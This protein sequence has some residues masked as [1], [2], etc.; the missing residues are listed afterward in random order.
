[1][2]FPFHEWKHLG[3]DEVQEPFRMAIFP[4]ISDPR[5]GPEIHEPQLAVVQVLA[6][7]RETHHDGL[8]NVLS[9]GEA[10]R[11]TG[12]RRKTP[13]AVRR[14]DKGILSIGTLLERFRQ[15]YE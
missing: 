7:I 2:V 12:H 5:A 10:A 6:V 9:V 8:R 4:R 14:Q 13:I 11:E 1:M 3:F 15:A